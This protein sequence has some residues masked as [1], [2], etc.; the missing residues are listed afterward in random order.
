MIRHARVIISNA[1]LL[2]VHSDIERHNEGLSCIEQSSLCAILLPYGIKLGTP[3]TDNNIFGETYVHPPSSRW[4][5]NLCRL[6]TGTRKSATDNLF[7]VSSKWSNTP[8]VLGFLMPSLFAV[9]KFHGSQ[10]L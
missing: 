1:V 4:L 8:A 10:Q 7:G 9:R 3:T 5:S 2:F 6:Y